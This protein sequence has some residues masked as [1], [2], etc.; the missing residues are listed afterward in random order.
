M[1]EDFNLDRVVKIGEGRHKEIFKDLHKSDDRVTAVLKGEYVESEKIGSR[2]MKGSFYLTKILHILFPMVIPDIHLAASQPKKLFIV[3]KK[4]RS[5]E[6]LEMQKMAMR[7]GGDYDRF[8]DAENDKYYRYDAL[9]LDDPRYKRFCLELKSLG[10][11]FDESRHNFDYDKEGN[12]VYL[13]TGF[14]P[15]DSSVDDFAISKFDANKLRTAL[16][17]LNDDKK[18]RGLTYLQHLETLFMEEDKELQEKAVLE[19]QNKS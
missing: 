4:Q 11:N 15:W 3:E 2:R 8:N 6:H 14:D 10:I 9:I 13:E 16:E 17:K 7:H 12:L 1:Q 5:K 19:K 18:E